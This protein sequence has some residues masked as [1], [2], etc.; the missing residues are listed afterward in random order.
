VK[1]YR[2]TISCISSINLILIIQSDYGGVA[3]KDTSNCRI[4]TRIDDYII[5]KTFN[6]HTYDSEAAKIK[7][8]VA[9]IKI[10]THALQTMEPTSLVINECVGPLSQAAK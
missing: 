3:I 7:I 9:V 6:V 10:K 2:K 8:E 5:Q 1:F 4:H